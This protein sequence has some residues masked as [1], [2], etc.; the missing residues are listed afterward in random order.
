VNWH[1]NECLG[2][3]A[4]QNALA[5]TAE[6]RGHFKARVFP[7]DET[8]SIRLEPKARINQTAPQVLIVLFDWELTQLQ[9]TPLPRLVGRKG[10][11]T[12]YDCTSM[13]SARSGCSEGDCLRQ[14]EDRRHGY[15]LL[16]ARDQPHY[17]ELHY[18]TAIRPRG[19][20]SLA[21]KR[22]WKWR[23]KSSHASC[24]RG[25][26]TVKAAIRKTVTAKTMRKL[27]VSRDELFRRPGLKALLNSGRTS[28]ALYASHQQEDDDDHEDK[29]DTA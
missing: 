7:E 21:I 9:H 19:R 23:C 28:G 16:W 6:S 18:D 25:C 12:G 26:G 22:K 2:D 10:W 27:G 13:R 5:S 17:Q 14:P 3:G 4:C 11:P 20:G 29:A 24:W 1:H 15:L 8:S